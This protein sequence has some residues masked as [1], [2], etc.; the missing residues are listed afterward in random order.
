[1]EKVCKSNWHCFW[2]AGGNFVCPTS[3]ERSGAVKVVQDADGCVKRDTDFSDP[4]PTNVL[5]SRNHQTYPWKS[6]D[7]CGLK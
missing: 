1:M 5:S 3:E 2:N 4:H 6:T 7:P